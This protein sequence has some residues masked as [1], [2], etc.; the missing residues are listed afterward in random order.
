MRKLFLTV[1]FLVGVV[2]LQA[3]E[4]FGNRLNLSVGTSYGNGYY[5]GHSFPLMLNY[6]FDVA[7]NFTLA[8]FISF[9]TYSN[10]YITQNPRKNFYAYQYNYRTVVVPVGVKG[11]YYFDELLN[12]GEKWDFYAAVSLGFAFRSTTWEDGYVVKD[13]PYT[14]SGIYLN[15]HAGAEYHFTE[16]I[17][18]FLDLSSG[19]SNIGMSIKVR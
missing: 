18:M 15:F 11:S 14:E 19:S 17:G 10:Y 4:K 8:P 1:G 6:E 3:Q 16:K 12:A 9:Y 5:Y 2:A 13:V 7:R